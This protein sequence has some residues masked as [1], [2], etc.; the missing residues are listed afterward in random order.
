MVADSRE[1]RVASGRVAGLEGELD[2]ATDPEL[3]K[4]DLRHASGA[5]WAPWSITTSKLGELP[6]AVKLGA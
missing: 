3:G 2:P 1:V 6:Q 5:L 4:Q